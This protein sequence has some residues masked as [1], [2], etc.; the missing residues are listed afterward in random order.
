MKLPKVKGYYMLFRFTIDFSFC[1]DLKGFFFPVQ[2][3]TN[4]TLG[5]QASVFLRTAAFLFVSNSQKKHYMP[6]CMDVK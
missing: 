5:W 6:K 4:N 3:H 1:F 2:I